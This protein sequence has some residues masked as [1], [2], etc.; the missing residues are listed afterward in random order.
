VPAPGNILTVQQNSATDP[1]ADGWTTYSSR[2]WKQN[3]VPITDAL[4]T[5]QRLRGVTFDWK[6]TGR[7]DLGM[8]AEEV[9][10]V[11]PEVVAFEEN[12]TDARSI[13]YAR[14]TALLVEATKELKAENDALRARLEAMERRL[15]GRG[16]APDDAEGRTGALMR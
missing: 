8:I 7:H 10:A 13:D 1:I 9:G 4:A 6:E 5:V 14:L 2:R 11:V 3:I 16:G 15:A 12:G